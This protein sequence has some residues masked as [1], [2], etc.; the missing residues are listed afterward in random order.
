M[1]ITIASLGVSQNRLRSVS[2][3]LL[4][5][6]LGLDH[7][8]NHICK[9]CNSKGQCY[10]TKLPKEDDMQEDTVTDVV[11]VGAGPSGLVLAIALAHYKVRVC[12]FLT[13]RL[14]HTL[15]ETAVDNT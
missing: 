5:V 7:A 11:I 3:I 8:C 14:M 1:S 15:T 9:D 10:L 12:Q 4:V 2:R 6:S 13:K